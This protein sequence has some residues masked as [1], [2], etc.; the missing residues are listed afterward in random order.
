MYCC[1]LPF[2]QSMAWREKW[3]IDRLLIDWK[4]PE[5]M[6]KYFPG[7][8]CGYDRDGCPIWICPIGRVDMKGKH[9]WPWAEQL[10]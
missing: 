3:K 7:G 4:P 6:P 1:F 5:A 2:Y 10:N 9:M 8:M